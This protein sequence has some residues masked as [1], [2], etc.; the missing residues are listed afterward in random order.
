MESL[1]NYKRSVCL[2]IYSNYKA[3][4]SSPHWAQMNPI[5][6]FSSDSEPDSKQRRLPKCQPAPLISRLLSA[7]S[8][9]SSSDV[10]MLTMMMMQSDT[11]PW[12][13]W[14]W[15]RSLMWNLAPLFAICCWKYLILINILTLPSL[16][17]AAAAAAPA[18]GP[19]SHSNQWGDPTHR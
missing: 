4:R 17:G 14:L 9:A 7:C 12:T 1:M 11:F 3:V 5:S 15:T 6:T 18:S 2:K 16:L 8:V 10:S 13:R 19:Y